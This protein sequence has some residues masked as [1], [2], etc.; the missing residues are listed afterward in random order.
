MPVIATRWAAQ[1]LTSA[2]ASS[3]AAGARASGLGVGRLH[4]DRLRLQHGTE[5]H[6]TDHR[7]QSEGYPGTAARAMSAPMMTPSVSQNRLT[8]KREQY[9]PRCGKTLTQFQQI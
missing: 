9:Q 7:A 3:V 8:G 5:S 2:A 4:H 6:T 1:S